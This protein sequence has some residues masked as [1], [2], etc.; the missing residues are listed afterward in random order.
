[1]C[2]RRG[3]A[4]GRGGEGED[5]A[6]AR[7][8][9][10][11][12][13]AVAGKSTLRRVAVGAACAVV[14]LVVLEAFLAVPAFNGATQI[15]PASGLGPVL[16]LFFGA[17]GV[18]GSAAGNLLS[19]A[20][21]ESDPVVLLEYFAIQLIYD[22]IPL[23]LW[24]WC[25][26]R[27]EHPALSSASRIAV[28]LFSAFI[29]SLAVT[30]LLVPFEFDSMQALNIHVVRLLNNF[31]ALIYVGM[32]T[33]LL[34]NRLS[35]PHQG[36]LPLPQRVA[37]LSLVMAALASATCLLAFVVPQALQAVSPERFASLVA[38]VYLMLSVVTVCFFGGA[39]LLLRAV[40]RSLVRPLDAFSASAREFPERFKRVG[41]ARAAAGALDVEL[42]EAKP[43]PEIAQ[44]IDASNA[45]R[46]NLGENVLAARAADRERAHVAAELDVAA[47]IQL[48]SVPR[49]FAD[50]ERRY[51]V[52]VD[53]RMQPAREVGGDF[54]DV[55]SLDDTRLCV[56]IADVSDKGVPAALFM[57]RS[58]AE[59]RECIRTA[60]S[61]VE[62]FIDANRRLCEQNASMQFVT[63]FA[64][65]LDCVTGVAA[66]VNAGH[67]PPW[68]QRADGAGEFLSVSP[69][70]PLGAW[71]DFEYEGATLVL[72]P[73]D[74]VALYTDGVTEARNAADDM[75]G[76]E[77]LSRV[78]ASS[79]L[80]PSPFA[81]RNAFAHTVCREVE[82]AVH[83]FSE[84]VEQSDDLTVV[85]LTW[86]P[87]METREFF[88][89]IAQCTAAQEF[90][91]G[92]AQSEDTATNYALDVIVEELFANIV[93]HGYG[94]DAESATIELAAGVDAK[95][96]IVHMVFQDEGMAF[97]P[98]AHVVS[99]IEGGGDDDLQVGGMGLLMVRTYA[100][101][102]QY[103]RVGAH[104]VLHVAKRLG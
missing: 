39:C 84:D 56:L 59:L 99:P 70:L 37:L 23:L 44:L 92:V 7:P 11:R 58:M 101:A 8:G 34:L 64:L 26:P 33:L 71:D 14:Y 49:D 32:P 100:E 28:Y 98:L 43:L 40:D 76:S 82:R 54:Y 24:H 57:M 30:L 93:L 21:R 10:I 22:A 47:S 20:L 13:G 78:L 73:G 79:V 9:A 62:G 2:A 91:R 88:A 46:R 102:L 63:A 68:L 35:L 5:A 17:P 36:T 95:R 55:F 38:S 4:D 48:S 31:L 19:D 60:P 75:F 15:R 87:M 51:A 18:V 90:I 65:V 80:C 69:G 53:A 12:A 27:D 72:M 41:A 83:E 29:A 103:A 94:E 6:R 66:I 52:A 97:D 77:R 81:A 89:D 96:G 61:L 16:G 104:N 67:N 3:R 86:L 1:M 42:D 25:F 85:A 74:S 45:M 50:I